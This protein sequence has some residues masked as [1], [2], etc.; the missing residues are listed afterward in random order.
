MQLRVSTSRLRRET[1]MRSSGNT[2]GFG[3]HRHDGGIV[4][5]KT[6]P[7]VVGQARSLGILIVL[8]VNELV[9]EACE[10]QVSQSSAAASG[11]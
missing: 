11:E 3:G 10:Q 5:L 8:N 2:E 7:E 6:K 9:C 1:R 4:G